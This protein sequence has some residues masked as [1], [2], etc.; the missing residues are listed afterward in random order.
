MAVLPW[1]IF[2]WF[3][4]LSL[5]KIRCFHRTR[6]CSTVQPTETVFNPISS[7]RQNWSANFFFLRLDHPVKL[8]ILS[9]TGLQPQELNHWKKAQVARKFLQ[10]RSSKISEQALWIGRSYVSFLNLTRNIGIDAAHCSI[11]PGRSQQLFR[12]RRF[13]QLTQYGYALQ[14][15]NPKPQGTKH[16]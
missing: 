13:A 4:A 1:Q 16:T 10:T 11:R 2:E 3:H 9:I 15:S 12:A 8:Q 5:R 7:V 14:A 6:D